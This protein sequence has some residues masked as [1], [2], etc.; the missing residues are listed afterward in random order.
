MKKKIT[1]ENLT[2]RCTDALHLINSFTRSIGAY[3]DGAKDLDETYDSI[4]ELYDT[5]DK[6]GFV[7]D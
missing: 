3:K 2:V 6:Y 1:T 4:M 7:H 5:C